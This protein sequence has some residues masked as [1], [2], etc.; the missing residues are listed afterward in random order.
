MG[1]LRWAGLQPRESTVLC[2]LRS[3]RVFIEDLLCAGNTSEQ[4]A[5]G[6]LLPTWSG[7]GEATGE[8]VA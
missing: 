5:R 7:A 4:T 1:Q 8:Y 2:L 3:L 6:L